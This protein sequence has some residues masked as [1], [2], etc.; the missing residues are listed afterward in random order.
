MSRIPELRQLILRRR[1]SLPYVLGPDTVANWDLTSGGSPNFRH[2]I[3]DPTNGNDANR[4]YIDAAPGSTLAPTGIARRTIAGFFQVFPRQGAGRSFVILIMNPDHASGTTY[5]DD[6]DFNGFS[7][8]RWGRKSGSTDGTNS[9]TDSILAGARRLQDGPNADASWTVAGGATATNIPIAAGTLTAEVS[10]GGLTAGRVRFTGN[11]TA[12]LANVCA[13]ILKNDGTNIT[14]GTNLTVVPAAGDTFFVERPG[15][16]V[17]RYQEFSYLPNIIQASPNATLPPVTVGIGVTGTTVF[18][19]RLG[20]LGSMTYTFCEQV[21]TATSQ[22]ATTRGAESGVLVFSGLYTKEGSAT[23]INLGAGFRCASVAI[24]QGADV[25]ASEFGFLTLNNADSNASSNEFVASGGFRTSRTFVARG[26]RITAGSGSKPTGAGCIIGPQGAA[27]IQRVRMVDRGMTVQGPHGQIYG[28]QGDGCGSAVVQ[29]GGNSPTGIPTPGGHWA[30]DDVVNGTTPNTYVGIKI[31]NLRMGST[32]KIGLRAPCTASG[33][34][35]EILV[36]SGIDVGGGLSAGDSGL[37]CT[38][39][40]LAKTNVPDWNG[41]NTVGSAGTRIAIGSCKVVTN[42]AGSALAVGEVVKYNGTTGQVVRA[43]ATGAP[44]LLGPHEV[45]GVMVTPA[46]NNEL[47]LMF[48]G[49][50]S[51]YVLTD[52][53]PAASATLYLSA[54]VAGLATTA[55]PPAAGAD[56]KLRLGGVGDVLTVPDATYAAPWTPET[57]SV[58]ADGAR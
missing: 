7:G 21:S 3:I 49:G 48:V 34:T 36:A 25:A 32:V 26:V 33:T 46:A 45:A 41:T 40:T 14:P 11:V 17:P 53:A 12:S 15:V 56:R 30:I 27:T 18:S 37:L 24:L 47:G 8:Y 58:P 44:A 54:A 5:A 22:I 43:Q 28:V 20:C 10:G 42:K 38:Y 35:G 31:G 23:N 2:F 19:C 13:F 29:V 57:L 16:L 52:G 55:S 9:A 51:P 39:A 4:G 50:G 1:G 6:F